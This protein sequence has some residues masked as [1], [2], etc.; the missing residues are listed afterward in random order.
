M[1]AHPHFASLLLSQ[2]SSP[3][4]EGLGK[5]LASDISKGS[6]LGNFGEACDVNVRQPKYFKE[7]VIQC[8]HS[9]FGFQKVQ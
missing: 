1:L 9:K 8:L 4:T 6:L 7:W 2:V 3:F 5:Q